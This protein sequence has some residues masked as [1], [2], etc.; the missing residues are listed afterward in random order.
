[1]T[2]KWR[3]QVAVAIMSMSLVAGSS[4]AFAAELPNTNANTSTAVSG[5]GSS[6]VTSTGTYSLEQMLTYA[7]QDEY[8]A[9]A[10]YAA[11]IKTFNTARPYTNILKAE[12]T[13]IDYLEPLFAKYGV[14]IPADSSA[15]HVALPKTLNETYA[16]GVDAEI[17]NIQM[18]ETFLKQD[19]PAD[20]KAVFLALKDASVKHLDAFQRQVDKVSGTSFGTNSGTS[21]T[22]T[23]A[24]GFGNGV[25]RNS[26]NGLG[27]NR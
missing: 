21:N 11:I 25:G 27:R 1:M 7:I 9:Q 16:I 15:S 5:W 14:T 4:T 8:A 19:L 23:S 10:E 2:S 12:G 6:A 13:H 26:A 20:V 17:K 22:N 3:K 18:Y 24:G